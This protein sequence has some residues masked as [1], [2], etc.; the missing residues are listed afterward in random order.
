MVSLEMFRAERIYPLIDS[1]EGS[2]IYIGVG[3]MGNMIISNLAMIMDKNGDDATDVDFVLINTER[4]DIRRSYRI[5]PPRF[6]NRLYIIVIGLD[7]QELDSYSRYYKV[8]EEMNIGLSPSELYKLARVAMHDKD[9]FVKAVKE[10]SLTPEQFNAVVEAVRGIVRLSKKLRGGGKRFDKGYELFKKNYTLLTDLLPALEGDVYVI[11]SSLAGATGSGGGV[12]TTKAVS[13]NTDGFI[14]Y[15]GFKPRKIDGMRKNE[16]YMVASR[17]IR[18]FSDL[19][20]EHDIDQFKSATPIALNNMFSERHARTLDFFRRI[21]GDDS[22]GTM[23]TNIDPADF[24]TAIRERGGT[25]GHMYYIY[26]RINSPDDLKNVIKRNV[27]ELIRK[28]PDSIVFFIDVPANV[29]IE[30]VD[31][32][33]ASIIDV[34]RTD[35]FYGISVTDSQNE[36]WINFLPLWYDDGNSEEKKTDVQKVLDFNTQTIPDLD[37]VF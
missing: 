36:V 24:R 16:N 33:M 15:S 26:D 17:E 37:L 19:Y 14:V 34:G 10:Y 2:Q 4:N 3:G 20:I 12:L 29:R 1:Y 7:A 18:K 30:N 6:R 11:T 35:N 27:G 25:S 8:I 9:M 28:A 31:E 32:L 13:E 21:F 5:F 22:S 23:I